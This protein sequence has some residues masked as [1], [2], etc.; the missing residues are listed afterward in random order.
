MRKKILDI[1]HDSAL[2]NR[3]MS[4]PSPWWMVLMADLLIVALSCFATF[5]FNHESSNPYLGWLGSPF[6]QGVVVFAVYAALMMVTRT[7]RYIVRLSVVE[8]MYR[9]V[10]L[11]VASST[12]LAITS[13]VTSFAFGE[14][15]FNL[16]NIFVIGLLSFTLMMFSRLGIKY[17]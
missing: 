4:A 2:V 6:A 12:V 15:Y 7:F 5:T 3:F 1:L 9:V 14:A 16:W 11:T 8:D 13:L 17:I 10:A